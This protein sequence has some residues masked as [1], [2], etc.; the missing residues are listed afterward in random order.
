[1][2]DHGH[3]P[4]MTLLLANQRATFLGQVLVIASINI[5]ASV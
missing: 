5:S 4:S 1:M 2:A 3:Y